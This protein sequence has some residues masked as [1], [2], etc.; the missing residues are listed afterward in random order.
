VTGISAPAYAG[1]SIGV[2]VTVMNKGADIANSTY[3]VFESLPKDISVDNGGAYDIASNSTAMFPVNVTVGSGVSG[4]Y[5][6]QFHAVSGNL[7]SENRTIP[8]QV[9]NP[10]AA[11]AKS[12]SPIPG[13][14]VV[15]A[16][17]GLVIAAYVVS[18]KS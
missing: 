7:T 9:G 16:L 10:T 12:K 15:A 3:L 14:E 4:N 13:F 17:V 18:R 2:N 6:L 5:D 8:I 11:A 1:G